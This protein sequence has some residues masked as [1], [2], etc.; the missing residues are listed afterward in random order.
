MEFQ[1]RA[2]LREVA[3]F[4]LAYEEAYQ[5]VEMTDAFLSNPVGVFFPIPVYVIMQSSKATIIDSYEILFGQLPNGQ[6]YPIETV[7]DWPVNAFVFAYHPKDE[8]YNPSYDLEREG[9]RYV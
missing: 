6:L 9:G 4:V 3:E 7:Q 1:R 8:E 5:A 2:Q